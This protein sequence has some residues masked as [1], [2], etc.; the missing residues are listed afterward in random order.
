MSAAPL[1]KKCGG[2]LVVYVAKDKRRRLR[3]FPCRA[4]KDRERRAKIKAG[5]HV[6]GTRLSAT[7]KF[8]RQ[9]NKATGCWL[10]MGYL[11]PQGYGVFKLGE[12]RCRAHRYAWILTHGDIPEGRLV[13]HHCDNP[14]CVNPSHLFLGSHKDNIR[15]AISKGRMA[16]QKGV[17][18]H[19]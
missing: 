17:A 18:I 14:T 1:C 3:C 5:T 7:E 19:A 13:C 11:S 10:W 6:V 12:S 16:W 15:D 8:W 4:K 9:V 2:P